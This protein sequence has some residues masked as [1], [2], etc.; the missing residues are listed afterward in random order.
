MAL[1]KDTAPVNSNLACDRNDMRALLEAIPCAISLW[2]RDRSLCLLNQSAHRLINY[3]EADFSHCRSLWVDRIHPDDRQNFSRSQEAL[4]N[5]KSP[6]QCDYRFSPRNAQAPI[7]LREIS[8]FN[9]RH[10]KVCW[11]IFSV[12]TDVSDLKAATAAETKE[13]DVMNAIKLL[14]HE[15]RNCVQ[16]II[17]ELEFAKLGLKGNVHSND[18]VSAVDTVNRSVLSLRDQLEWLF[19]SFAP[20]DPSAILDVIVQKLRKE[21]HRRRVNLRLVRRGPLPMVRG[22]RNQLLSAF[23]RVFEFCGAMLTNGGKLEVEAGP[24]EVGGQLY[25]QVKVI[26]SS[27]ASLEPDGRGAFQSYAGEGHQIG[28]GIGLGAEILGRYRGQVSFRKE[29]KNRGEVTILIKASPN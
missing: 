12:Y 19:E 3:T 29:G 11:D 26:S 18:L 15:L 9:T 7:W 24:K 14:S 21:L 16:K 8:A 10:G 23:E 28:L 25:A 6:V 20:Y 13:D 22:D 1:Y 17:M 5:G 27:A 2:N 4:A